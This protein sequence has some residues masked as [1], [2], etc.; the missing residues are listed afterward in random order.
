[1]NWFSQVFEVAVMNLRSVPQRIGASLV[2]VIGIAGVVASA[3]RAARHGGGFPADA[4][5]TGRAD[6]AIVHALRR[7]RRAVERLRP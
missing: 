6:R 1:M 7:H 3:G 4:R 5:S 2:I